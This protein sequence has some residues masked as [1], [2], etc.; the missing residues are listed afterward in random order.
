MFQ[1]KFTADEEEEAPDYTWKADGSHLDDEALNR[2]KKPKGLPYTYV[3]SDL[4][5]TGTFL[6]PRLTICN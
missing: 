1:Y 5:Q 2:T 3:P 6:Y 4:D